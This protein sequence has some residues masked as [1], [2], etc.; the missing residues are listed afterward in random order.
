MSVKKVSTKALGTKTSRTSKLELKTELLKWICERHATNGPLDRKLL[1]EK[2]MEIADSF[3]LIGYKCPGAFLTVFLKKYG[4]SP[5]LT[6]CNGPTFTDYR[7]WIDLLRSLITQYRYK[8]LFNVDELIMYSNYLPSRKGMNVPLQKDD[9]NVLENHERFHTSSESKRI[10]ILLC[11][12]SSGTEKLEPLISNPYILKKGAD[13][14]RQKRR[15]V[16]G[17]SDN[18]FAAWLDKLNTQMS[19][20]QRN[21][22]LL[23]SRERIRSLHNFQSLSNVK[24]LFLPKDFPAQLRPLRG[25]VFHSVKMTYR[26]RYVES[27]RRREPL[28]KDWST[29]EIVQSVFQ[30]W[31]EVS[32][33]LIVASFQ[34]T[35]FREDQSFLKIQ[36]PEWDSC[37]TGMSFR[38]YVTFDDG[39]C[40][41][42]DHRGNEQST[43]PNFNNN[44]H[45]YNLRKSCRETVELSDDS[46][47]TPIE[48]SKKARDGKKRDAEMVRNAR[49]DEAPSDDQLST[50]TRK[51]PEPRG[52]NQF[53]NSRIVQFSGFP[54]ANKIPGV[55]N[56]A[57]GIETVGAGAT[58]DS[59]E[60]PETANSSGRKIYENPEKRKI[61][62]DRCLRGVNLASSDLRSE[63][64]PKAVEKFD[65]FE[66]NL[67]PGDDL[68]E[69]VSL[70]KKKAENLPG[71]AGP[72]GKECRESGLL[73][74]DANVEGPL[75]SEDEE[76]ARGD[77]A[78]ARDDGELRLKILT[79]IQICEELEGRSRQEETSDPISGRSKR[80]RVSSSVY[81]DNLED[82][83]EPPNK[84]ARTDAHWSKRYET[85]FAFG[86]EIR[87]NLDENLARSPPNENP[88]NQESSTTNKSLINQTGSEE[89]DKRCRFTVDDCTSLANEPYSNTK[90]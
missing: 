75:E 61:L 55:P 54:G 8:D 38:E 16:S 86:P 88:S 24:L 18:N 44:E 74:G 33:N 67:A 63:V 78:G 73:L 42:P 25:D 37:E 10:A 57:L 70:Q 56:D 35:K 65:Q 6:N 59:C 83:D 39:L 77:E 28:T 29:K 31:Q 26:R 40:D 84:V 5:T 20:S 48:E 2:A 82:D 13:G 23:L 1:R 19:N 9:E 17:I 85:N 46:D 50:R 12:N 47:E 4:F 62:M 43:L 15:H 32:E 90:D 3:G 27:M 21:V 36:C 22:L 72:S 51:T 87:V 80:S 66:G 11:C 58:T 81:E 89:V 64:I 14:A 69:G 76:E 53:T 52:K 41:T 68:G 71:E 7:T 45:G 34:R 49:P 79:A 60:Y 30:A